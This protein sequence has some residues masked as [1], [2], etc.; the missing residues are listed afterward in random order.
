MVGYYASLVERLQE[1]LDFTR[2]KMHQLLDE[3]IPLLI[4]EKDEPVRNF[5]PTGGSY[6]PS[7]RRMILRKADRKRA[8]EMKREQN[9]ILG[10]S[11]DEGGTEIPEG[12]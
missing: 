12:Y 4:E 1:E 8:L 11:D 9:V 2:V 7:V 6:P 3:R 10:E 5:V